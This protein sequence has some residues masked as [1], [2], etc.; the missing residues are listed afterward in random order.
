MF[1]SGV[2]ILVAF[3]IV[4]FFSWEGKLAISF[5]G[6]LA[7]VYRYRRRPSAAKISNFSERA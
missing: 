2:G 6:L 3:E 5:S 1:L 4:N 7:L